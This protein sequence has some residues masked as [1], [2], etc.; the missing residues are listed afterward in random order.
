MFV[1][2]FWNVVDANQTESMVRQDKFG[3]WPNPQFFGNDWKA[4]VSK[5]VKAT[6]M[7]DNWSLCQSRSQAHK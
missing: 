7:H 3:R 2:H 6:V 1:T 4:K 5:S